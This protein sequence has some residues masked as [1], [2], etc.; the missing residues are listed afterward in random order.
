M[1]KI[2]FA[3]LLFA[4]S[5][6]VAPGAGFADDGK[7]PT[8]NSEDH[9]VG[10]LDAPV[11]IFE[12][13]SLACPHCAAFVQEK[14]PTLR[15]EWIDTGKAKMVYRDFPTNGEALK[16]AAVA[17]CAP[18][19]QYFAFIESFFATQERWLIAK[20][21]MTALKGIAR[22]GGMDAA[23]F[24]RCYD[25]AKIQDAI[26]AQATRARDDYGVDATPT[27]FIIGPNGRSTRLV[28]DLPLADF[29]KALNEALPKS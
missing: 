1:S 26:V 4:V 6:L 5:A 3:A 27:F 25:D 10:K 2:L 11:T 17:R 16:A 24:D 20:D 23:T 21:P 28:G 29:V 14:L 12:Y 13:G 18:P 8:I 7:L 9:V 15:K 19:D 22:L